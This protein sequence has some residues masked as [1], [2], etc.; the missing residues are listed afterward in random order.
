MSGLDKSLDDLIN[1][2]RKNKNMG[3]NSTGKNRKGK[4]AASKKLSVSKGRIGKK[5]MGNKMMMDVDQDRSGKRWKH[6]KFKSGGA[7][8]G[9]QS[10]RNQPTRVQVTNLAL[11]VT[12]KDIN[13]LFSEVGQLRQAFVKF[14]RNGRSTGVAEVVFYD[15]ASAL[16]AIKRYNGVPLDGK[17]MKLSLVSNRGR[18]SRK[19]G[20]Q[21]GGGDDGRR[22]IIT[23]TGKRRGGRWRRKGLP[24]DNNERMLD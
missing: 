24:L 15:R 18:S 10:K 12:N 16:D 14:D 7:P 23:A 6:D 17:P 20:G 4:F 22:I 11:G 5:R 8:S 19:R 13:D 3:K 1:E 21:I 9:D 2:Q